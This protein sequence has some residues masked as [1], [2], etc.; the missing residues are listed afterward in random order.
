MVTRFINLTL[1]RYVDRIGPWVPSGMQTAHR[2]DEM[3]ASARKKSERGDLIRLG[4][5]SP[6]RYLQHRHPRKL[7]HGS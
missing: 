4:V 3:S 6:F 2:S 7:S 5:H 1:R